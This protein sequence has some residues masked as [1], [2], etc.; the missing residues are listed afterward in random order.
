MKESE[1]EEVSYRCTRKKIER[2]GGE[3]KERQNCIRQI[4]GRRTN[5]QITLLL[6]YKYK[7]MVW[8]GSMNIKLWY[9]T[10][11]T[12]REVKNN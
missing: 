3:F 8:Y 2:D 1:E 11:R 4:Y 12:K 10:G 9:A 6:E 7:Y 5:L